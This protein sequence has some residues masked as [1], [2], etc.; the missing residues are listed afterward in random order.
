MTWSI[1]YS[2]SGNTILFNVCADVGGGYFYILEPDGVVLPSTVGGIKIS[3]SVC[4]SFNVQS[5]ELIK[6]GTYTMI[7]ADST[8]QEMTRSQVW[9]YVTPSP[10]TVT[11]PSGSSQGGTPPPTISPTPPSGSICSSDQINLMGIC[12]SRTLLIVAGVG[13]AALLVFTKK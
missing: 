8:P 3:S 12:L 1:N 4:T 6:Q 5:I 7:L 11:P 2:T 13:I 9:F 10:F